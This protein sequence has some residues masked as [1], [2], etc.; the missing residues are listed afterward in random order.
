MK[1]AVLGAGQAGCTIAADLKSKGHEVYLLELS[2]FSQTLETIRKL[3]GIH[4]YGEMTGTY[5]P[6]RLTTDPSEA[7]DQADIAMVAIPGFAHETFMETCFPHFS[8]NQIVLNWT[9]YWSSLRLFPR[10]RQ[11]GRSDL[12]LAEAAIMPFMTNVESP[13]GRL[14]VRAVKQ[15]LFV[16]AM[17]ATNNEK[18]VKVVGELYP[19]TVG[20]E[21][22]L[23][24][25]LN[26]MNVPIH[27]PTWLMNASLWE[28]TNGDFD[29]FGYGFTA[30]VQRVVDAIDNER[31]GV[32]K[33][34]GID[35]LTQGEIGEMVYSKYGASKKTGGVAWWSHGTWRAKGVSFLKYGE[36]DVGEDCPFGLVPLSSLGDEL[37]VPTPT[38]DSIIQ[39]ASVAGQKDFRK[40]G[41]DV[42]RMGIKGMS[43]ADILR[44]VTHGA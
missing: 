24:T 14:F 22:V 16:A 20:A 37:S 18:V 17:P 42:E 26:N 6:D 3:G 11:I 35:S 19:Q 8:K 2:Q 44:Y 10:M 12:I 13:D 41:L 30:P 40:M 36:R 32:S 38:I 15:R 34:L 4:V 29:F 39:L 43:K 9:P 7:L 1:I 21:N 28:R 25:S 31:L 5:M 23:W 33:A 27:V